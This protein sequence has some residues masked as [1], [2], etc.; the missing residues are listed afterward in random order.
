MRDDGR[1]PAASPAMGAMGG[2]GSGGA[3]A[4][5]PTATSTL[6]IVPTTNESGAGSMSNGSAIISSP[7]MP[8]TA[9]ASPQKRSLLV[10]AGLALFALP[11]FLL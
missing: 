11:L 1:P 5:A 8:V 2:A 4:A 10:G 6:Q 9:G 3:P 7:T